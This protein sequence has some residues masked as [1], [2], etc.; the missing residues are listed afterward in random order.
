MEYQQACYRDP[1]LF[2]Q[3]FE[4]NDFFFPSSVSGLALSAFLRGRLQIVKALGQLA[5]ESTLRSSSL[6]N[7]AH[8]WC[9]LITIINVTNMRS[10]PVAITFHMRRLF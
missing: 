4:L 5:A 6:Q 9:N 7:C 8:K 3:D 10:V 2:T 1:F